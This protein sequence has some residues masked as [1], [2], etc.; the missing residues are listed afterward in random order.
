MWWLCLF[1]TQ[2]SVYKRSTSQNM[3]IWEHKRSSSVI[4]HYVQ[5]GDLGGLK[6][7]KTNN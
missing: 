3:P 6:Y 2:R 7:E 1:F 5:L 4:L